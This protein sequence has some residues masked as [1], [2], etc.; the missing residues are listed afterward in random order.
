[1]INF[2]ALWMSLIFGIVVSVAYLIGWVFGH[3][4][5][6]RCQCCSFDMDCRYCVA[7]KC[8]NAH[9]TDYDAPFPV[10]RE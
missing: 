7:A 1:M 2:G 3:R 6:R 10:S 4:A 8:P 5:G 9:P